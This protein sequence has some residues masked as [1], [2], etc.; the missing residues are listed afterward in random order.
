MLNENGLNQFFFYI[1]I[2]LLAVYTGKYS[3][4]ADEC[5]MRIFYFKIRQSE[6]Y[7]VHIK[8]FKVQ[9]FAECNLLGWLIYRESWY[10]GCSKI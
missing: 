4:E 3:D 9:V 6:K 8:H 5:F 7:D 2:E 10:R 1:E